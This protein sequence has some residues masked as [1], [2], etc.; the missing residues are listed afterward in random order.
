MPSRFLRNA[1]VFSQLGATK[2]ATVIAKQSDGQNPSREREL[3]TFKDG[4][5]G[6]C[7]DSPAVCA[8]MSLGISE[9]INPIV[10]AER[11][12]FAVLPA[13]LREI[14]DGIRFPG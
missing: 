11:T 14:C 12:E 6:Y 7:K 4:P 3:R 8:L 9:M 10:I 5:Y 1:K 2:S 13:D